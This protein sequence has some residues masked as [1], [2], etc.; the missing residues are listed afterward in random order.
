MQRKG[1]SYI[2]FSASLLLLG[3][4]FILFGIYSQVAFPNET[5]N[6]DKTVGIITSFKRVEG[7]DEARAP[8]VEY[9]VDKKNYSV[10]GLVAYSGFLG[11]KV[12]TKKEI[13]YNPHDPSDSFVVENFSPY[14]LI[15]Y[16]TIFA[17]LLL[18]LSTIFNFSHFEKNR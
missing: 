2:V 3:I 5:I 18:V 10:V 12:G 13:R 17:G 6:W 1:K 9:T 15:N 14:R 16:F 7:W 11:P 8:I 4:L